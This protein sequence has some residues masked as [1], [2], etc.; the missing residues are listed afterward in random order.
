MTVQEMA[1]RFEAY[2]AE[3]LAFTFGEWLEMNWSDREARQAEI[4]LKHGYKHGW[5]N[6][7]GRS[8]SRQEAFPNLTFANVW[9]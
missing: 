4:D 9:D 5:I 1:N 3:T 6:V 2:D 7:E 8:F